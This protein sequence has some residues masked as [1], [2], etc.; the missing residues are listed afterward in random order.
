MKIASKP[1]A[2]RT[3]AVTSPIKYIENAKGTE[4]CQK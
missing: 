3:A 1:T 2:K 4:T